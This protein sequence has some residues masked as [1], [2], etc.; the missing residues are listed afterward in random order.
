[1]RS[2]RALAATLMAVASLAPP[3]FSADPVAGKAAYN[4]LHATP[5][6]LG[7]AAAACHGTDPSVGQN[8]IRKGANNPGVIQSAIDSNKGSMGFLKPFFTAT[9]IDN[10][11]AYIAN[12]SAG[13]PQP[14]IRLSS[15]T[16]AFGSQTVLTTSAPMVVTVSNT[17]SANLTLQTL[18]IGG[19]NA[20]DFARAGTCAPGGS[21]APAASCTIALTFT[22]QSTG[23][24]SGSLSI[25]HNASGSPIAVAL[26]GTGASS[27][28]PAIGLSA[29]SLALGD[30]VI[31]TPSA[32]KTVTVT[33][34]GTAALMLNS[35]AVGG[36]NASDFVLSG[37]C[38]AGTNLVPQASCTASVIFTPSALGARTAAISIASNATGSPHSVALTGNGVAV[39]APAVKLSP[40]TV[41]FGNQMV[42]VASPVQNVTLNNS[43]GA[44]L[45]IGN[46]SV[47][48]AGFAHSSNCPA[49]LAAAASCTI[50]VTFTPTAAGAA[51]GALNVATNATGSPH[52]VALSGTGITEPAAMTRVRLRPDSL[53]FKAQLLNTPSTARIVALRNDGS[54][55][56]R[57]DGLRITGRQAGD[58]AQTSDCP[59][60]G[61]LASRASCTIRVVFTPTQAG[62]RKAAL[63]VVGNVKEQPKVQLKGTGVRRAGE[64][65]DDGDDED[66][67]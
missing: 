59:I 28:T 3:A 11:A 65:G 37:N 31:N 53:E 14:V 60:G 38:A 25:T 66:D 12:P 54:V 55:A 26:S 30:Q 8:S 20:A 27:P 4:N 19:A 48:G 62:E 51:T 63:Y 6:P 21:V 43:G 9:D 44:A 18:A 22:P 17:G 33:N 34:T 57:L 36:A 2:F 61:L 56:L 45:N 32:A 1:M 47:T 39:G 64:S 13:T 46:I 15:A 50:G 67:D 52:T 42:G 29:A 40:A 58:F 24:R 16:I 10:I 49:S 7:C 35:V 23:E 5:A 41:N